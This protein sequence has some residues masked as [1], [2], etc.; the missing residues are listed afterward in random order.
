MP[1]YLVHASFRIDATTSTE[2]EDMVQDAVE[3]TSGCFS[4]T[5]LE[6]V[7][8]DCEDN[9]CSCETNESDQIDNPDWNT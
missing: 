3:A 5:D 2:A 9:P 6:S 8:N 4:T 7:C 1:R